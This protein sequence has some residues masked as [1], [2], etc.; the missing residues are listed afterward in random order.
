MSVSVIHVRALWVTAPGAL[1]LLLVAPELVLGASAPWLV[2][3]P[4]PPSE[5][6]LSKKRPFP[7]VPW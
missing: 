2:A 4:H 6:S 5:G 7:F 3:P 1:M